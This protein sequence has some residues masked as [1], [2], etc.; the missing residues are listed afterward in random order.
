MQLP[1]KKPFITSIRRVEAIDDVVLELHSDEGLV[2]YGAAAPTVAITGESKPNIIE[3]IEKS[4]LPLIIGKELDTSLLE[5]IQNCCIKHSSAKACVDIALYDL[6]SQEAKQPLYVYLGGK[7]RDLRTCIT[8][9]LNDTQEMVQNSIE[10]YQNGFKELKIKLGSD[11]THSIETVKSIHK[12]VPDA[13]LILDAN[14]AWDIN[15]AKE[16][17]DALNDLPI[18]LIEQ[19]LKKDELQQMAELTKESKYPILADES[20]FNIDEA[21]KIVALKG[22]DMINIKLMKCGGLL[23]AQKIIRYAEEQE[24]KCMIGS[25]LENPISVAAAAHFALSSDAITLLDLDAPILA[26]FNPI[27]NVFHY[28]KDLI[29]LTE[30]PGLGIEMKG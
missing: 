22:C 17:I 8:I 5:V 13:K 6:F 9:S 19:P 3:T 20:V 25:M 18:V 21:K 1:L 2:G 26:E 29:S 14:Q 11:I 15:S 4:I 12:N 30:K 10:A 24:I 28:E 16:I 27:D 7:K 23:E